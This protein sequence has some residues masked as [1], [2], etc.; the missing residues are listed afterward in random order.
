VLKIADVN[1]LFQLYRMTY[2]RIAEVTRDYGSSRRVFY[3]PFVNLFGLTRVIDIRVAIAFT[4]RYLHITRPLIIASYST[5]VFGAFNKNMFMT[6]WTRRENFEEAEDQEFVRQFYNN[7]VGL[8]SLAQLEESMSDSMYAIR[9]LQDF[10][11]T[12]AI[13][14]V[15]T[16]TYGPYEGDVA[17]IFGSRHP[18]NLKYDPV[19]QPLKAEEFYLTQVC[20]EK[21]EALT[22]EECR[23]EFEH[24]DFFD[25]RNKL[26][27]L[28]RIRARYTQFFQGSAV[29]RRLQVVIG[30][31]EAFQATANTARS[32]SSLNRRRPRPEI[33][34]EEVEEVRDRIE[35][36]PVPAPAR[37]ARPI[38]VPAPARGRR[39]RVGQATARGPIRQTVGTR[40]PN[41]LI[42]G[43]VQD[44]RDNPHQ[45]ATFVGAPGSEDRIN[46]LRATERDYQ[47]FLNFGMLNNHN[48]LQPLGL[49]I[50]TDGYTEWFLN[51]GEGDDISHSARATGLNRWEDMNP[52]QRNEYLRL[53]G[54]GVFIPAER[55]L[56]WPNSQT[57]GDTFNELAN[58]A[59]AFTR[60]TFVR[61]LQCNICHRICIG[62]DQTAHRCRQDINAPM[63]D[64][65]NM[66]IVRLLYPHDLFNLHLAELDINFENNEIEDLV[67]Q[68]IVEVLRVNNFPLIGELQDGELN[69]VYGNHSTQPNHWYAMAIDVWLR[70]NGDIGN[71]DPPRLIRGL[72]SDRWFFD[73]SGFLT[74]MTNYFNN[75][76]DARYVLFECRCNQYQDLQ[77]VGCGYYS[78]RTPTLPRSRATIPLRYDQVHKCA[79]APL[80]P[81]HVRRQPPNQPCNW[82]GARAR[83]LLDLPI[84]IARFVCY[85]FFA[86]EFEIDPFTWAADI[87]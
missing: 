47:D 81:G 64:K 57:V 39:R 2:D 13:G 83:T 86:G 37:D 46:Q 72:D 76:D 11:Y 28:G 22:N 84:E 8:T 87:E 4:S 9:T 25:T 36:A 7:T 5:T 55:M 80:R 6:C 19:I 23:R 60:R 78:V 10:N 31:I 82:G 1:Y 45:A 32:N 17:L 33:E 85:K 38:A 53:R 77:N 27:L 34:Q 62:N 73:K 44:R 79:V 49:I 3:R 14:R 43:A 21:L 50:G 15:Y 30:E 20:L 24:Y 18:G 69:H 40:V 41:N 65:A 63:I 67:I 26:L 56:F 70:N 42:Q 54:F 71:F 59:V 48:I 12:T 74:L 35:E 51:G 68:D 52:E 61:R 66:S 58:T 75:V 29:G 16:V